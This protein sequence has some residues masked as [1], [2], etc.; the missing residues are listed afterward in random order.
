MQAASWRTGLVFLA[1]SVLC[2]CGGHASSDNTAALAALKSLRDQGVL[3]QAEYDAKVAALSGNTAGGLGAGGGIDPGAPAA[4][5]D[6]AAFAP[7]GGLA[8]GGND[9]AGVAG[10]AGDVPAMPPHHARTRAIGANGA[11]AARLTDTGAAP[12]AT[13]TR[14]NV[15]RNLL[16]QAKAREAAVAHS[17]HEL[18]LRMLQRAPAGAPMQVP[19]AQDASALK[20]Y[21]QALMRGSGPADAA[22]ANAQQDAAA[23]R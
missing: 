22:A 21:G 1:C 20:S 2:A 11:N 9:F 23:P 4:G 6:P 3:T 10:A 15:M 8:A 5:S 19:S 14:S 7:D 18:A 13:D 17:A 16:A 12:S